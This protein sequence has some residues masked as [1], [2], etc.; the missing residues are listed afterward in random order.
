MFS[1]RV[2]RDNSLEF[3]EDK[4]RKRKRKKNKEEKRE[5]EK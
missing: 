3:K 2:Y 5:R 1:S 4:P